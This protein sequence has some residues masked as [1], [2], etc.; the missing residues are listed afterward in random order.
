MINLLE[1]RNVLVV[2]V[3]NSVIIGTPNVIYKDSRNSKEGE[4]ADTNSYH[5]G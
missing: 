2:Q 4:E 5:R 1:F 3:Q